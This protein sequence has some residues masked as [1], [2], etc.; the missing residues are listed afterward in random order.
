MGD[1]YHGGRFCRFVIQNI[2]TLLGQGVALV[3]LLDFSV[4]AL[5]PPPF[6]RGRARPP[7]PLLG[8]QKLCQ[9]KNGV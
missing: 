4:L 2:V 5:P 1:F 6:R 8:E 7:W 3:I 9:A